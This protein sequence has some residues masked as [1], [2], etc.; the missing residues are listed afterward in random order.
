MGMVRSNPETTQYPDMP[1][2][3]VRRYVPAD[4]A[5]IAQV[6]HASVHGLACANYAP[7][8]LDAWSPAPRDAAWYQ[9]RAGTRAAWVAERGGEIVGF[10][11][12]EPDGHV[13]M[14]Y[15]A[16]A[17]ARQGVAT[18]LYE[19]LEA[20]ARESGFAR[21]FVEASETALP[22]FIRMG[23]GSPQRR[24]FQR[25]GVAIHNYAMEKRLG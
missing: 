8:Q 7:E 21:L 24:D 18:A 20:Q 23:F 13:D 12:L 4:A 10:A 5:G 6:F 1:D 2:A 15:V 14:V 11:E 22:F 3:M 17:A 25:N 9:A 16:P 19:A